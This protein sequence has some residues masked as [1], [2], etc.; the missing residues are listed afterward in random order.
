MRS[1]PPCS[2]RR[3]SASSYAAGLVA[4]RLE[5]PVARLGER[6]QYGSR[7][8]GGERDEAR[9]A[10]DVPRLREPGPDERQPARPAERLHEGYPA[11]GRAALEGREELRREGSDDGVGGRL[12]EDERRP[13]ERYDPPGAAVEC[14]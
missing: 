9:Q 10:C 13:R 4:D 12:A 7:G 6:V 8:H 11:G 1:A 3:S 2:G 5:L 14:P